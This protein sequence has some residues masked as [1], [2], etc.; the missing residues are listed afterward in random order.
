[1]GVTDR[2]YYSS[3]YLTQFQATILDVQDQGHRIYL[4]QTAFYPTSGGQ[5]FDQG[6]LGKFSVTDVIDEEGRIAHVIENP[7]ESLRPGMT[8]QGEIDWDRR[9]DHMQQHSGQHLLS[10]IFAEKLQLETISVHLGET[11]STLDLDIASIDPQTLS[12]AETL[13]N[14]AVFENLQVTVQFEDA[15]IA[16]GLRKASERQGILRIVTIQGLDKSACGGNRS[17]S[18]PQNRKD[19]ECH[20]SGVCL[21]TACTG[22]NAC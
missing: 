9:F 6:T 5:L 21:W 18:D 12:S 7:D 10:A 2:L 20:A 13:A 15:A 22:S 17:H 14:R 19:P 16:E 1:M 8:I 3:S 4:D 11:V